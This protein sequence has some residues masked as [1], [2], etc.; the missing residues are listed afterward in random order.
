MDSEAFLVKFG[1][2]KSNKDKIEEGIKLRNEY[3][4]V[5]VLDDEIKRI[6]LEMLNPNL[7]PSGF[8]CIKCNNKLG[9]RWHENKEC[10]CYWCY[11]GVTDLEKNE[12]NDGD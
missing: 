12:N 4:G 11:V 10:L 6:K 7:I 5:K 9:K 8:P 3:L 1:Y 2:K